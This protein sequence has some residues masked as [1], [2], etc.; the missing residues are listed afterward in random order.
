MKLFILI[1]NGGNILKISDHTLNN[2]YISGNIEVEWDT[3]GDIDSFLKELKTYKQT[4][5]FKM[6]A[7]RVKRDI[8][9]KESDSLYIE[10]ETK[11]VKVQEIKEY[12]QLLRNLP[13]VVDIEAVSFE[14]MNSLFP[15]PPSLKE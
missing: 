5:D 2:N 7:L 12:K 6:K 11:G 10:A 4:S 1:E 3:E 14:N 13:D 8:L 9:L 15:S